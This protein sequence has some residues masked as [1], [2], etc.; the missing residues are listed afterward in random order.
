MVKEIIYGS[1][2]KRALEGLTVPQVPRPQ[3]AAPTATPP[4]PPRAPSPI[5][6]RQVSGTPENAVAMGAAGVTPP[7]R[8]SPIPSR[9]V[10]GTPESNAVVR[11]HGVGQPPG[12]PA[13]QVSGTPENA[14]AMQAAGVTPPGAEAM[15]PGAPPASEDPFGPPD[16]AR[17]PK[18]PAPKPAPVPGDPFE[19]T[20]PAAPGAAGKVPPPMHETMYKQLDANMSTIGQEYEAAMR[21]GDMDTVN[22]LNSENKANI[23]Q[24]YTE[25]AR[26]KAT[27]IATAE[28][29]PVEAVFG[30]MMAKAQSD[31]WDYE[32]VKEGIGT[33]IKEEAK[34]I[35]AKTGKP[36]E[37]VEKEL[38]NDKG[39]ISGAVEKFEGMSGWEKFGLILGG[40][41]ALASIGNMLFNGGGFGSML[42]A[43]L[44]IGVAGSS[45]GLFG[46]DYNIMNLLGVG[47]K[48]TGEGSN[49]TGARSN[50]T[51]APTPPAGAAPPTTLDT[52]FESGPW[53]PIGGAAPPTGGKPPS[54]LDN[55]TESGPW[56]P[57]GGAA[58]PPA[59]EAP[60]EPPTPVARG[61]GAP[62]G[63][64]PAPAGPAPAPTGPAP[65]A[66]PPPAA[67]PGDIVKTLMGD[68]TV[69]KDELM[70][71][72]AA[73]ERLP[74]AQQ[75]ELLRAAD[76]Q[77][78]ED[79]AG[80]KGFMARTIYERGGP[81]AL[82][83]TM[84]RLKNIDVT[85][86][87][88]EML[89]KLVNAA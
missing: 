65:P 63:P 28:G 44:G 18:P 31:G 85:P 79:L 51:S 11:E 62:T 48:A 37:V 80:L 82:A 26:R 81:E 41:T 15:P 76:P 59:G 52:M 49:A 72:V 32:D 30:E 14:A 50:A 83:S 39:V 16:P 34:G 75:Q 74:F 88:A 17:P 47:S 3:P 86:A 1:F 66:S 43:L 33:I 71:N 10:A 9:Q 56:G 29:K 22:R 21:S 36:P 53:G 4:Q 57:I 23:E 60:M 68:N 46:E 19:T 73:L 89:Y 2:V 64:A 45:A 7:G 8:P 5:P 13:R 77:L 69:T 12:F 42:T 35:A 27:E 55:P 38:K 40:I 58:A 6:A 20:E 54:I 25:R 87:Q 24:W 78:Q 61:T 67:G 84:K 70:S